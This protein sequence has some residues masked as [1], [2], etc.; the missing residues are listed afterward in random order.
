[1]SYVSFGKGKLSIYLKKFKPFLQDDL[2]VKEIINQKEDGRKIKRLETVSDY[3]SFGPGVLIY[4]IYD[5][6]VSFFR[7]W[8][9]EVNRSI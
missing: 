8:S 3:S 1:M 5:D 4:N 2:T 7:P 9:A 6:K